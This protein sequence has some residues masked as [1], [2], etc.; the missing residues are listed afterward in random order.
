MLT[1]FLGAGKTTTLKGILKDLSESKNAVIMNEF[2]KTG[3]DGSLL[4][5]FDIELSEINR[6]SIFCSCLQVNFVTELAR[7]AETDVDRVFVEGSGLADPS[8]IGEILE[9]LKAY[10]KAEDSPYIYA[11]AI[12]VVDARTFL[13]EVEEID[14]ITNQI[15]LAH[16]VI[17]NKSDLVDDLTGIREKVAAINPNADIHETTFGKMGMDFFH[18][19]G[20]LLGE[21]LKKETT[22]TV[23]TKPKTFT[24]NIRSEVS[25]P[26]LN[27]FL[28]EI[29]PMVYRVKGFTL[30][31][32]EMMKVD[33]VGSMIDVE[34]STQ[35][36]DESTLVF[37]TKKIEDMSVPQ[38]LKGIVG[39]WKRNTT[40]EMK[41]MNG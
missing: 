24:M 8:N 34:K 33:M 23:D 22:N 18:R 25:H 20:E 39:A 15:E 37:L 29:A 28:E 5:E 31:E 21:P 2:G 10:M 41:M 30:I 14:A 3:I 32:G 13:T 6:G 26:E 11:G 38:I 7:M 1:G 27:S 40:A 9:A 4:K 12:C 35:E 36:W 16:M 17:I 19:E